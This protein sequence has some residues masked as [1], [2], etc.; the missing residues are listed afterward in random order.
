MPEEQGRRRGRGQQQQARANIEL[1]CQP[2]QAAAGEFSVEVEAIATE[3]L[4]ALSGRNLQFFVGSA[5]FS[6]PER[7]DDNGRCR[8]KITG[9]IPSS[10]EVK[11]EVQVVGQATRRDITIKIPA[12]PAA[13]GRTDK[14][15]VRY[16]L[17]DNGN[18]MVAV[19]VADDK[20]K[21]KSGV[22]VTFVADGEVNTI[23]TNA[24]GIAARECSP[25][26]VKILTPGF[27]AND[28][29]L[30]KPP[31]RWNRPEP[32][33]GWERFQ[34]NNNCRLMW[35][36][37]AVGALLLFNL[38]FLGIGPEPDSGLSEIRQKYYNFYFHDQYA[39]DKEIHWAKNAWT[40]SMDFLWS[41]SWR[42]WWI[43]FVVAIVYT[44][45][46]LW[47]EVTRSF[48]AAWRAIQERKLDQ[49]LPD[50]P[51]QTTGAE[52]TPRTEPP[53]RGEGRHG[54]YWIFVREF[55]SALVAEIAAKGIRR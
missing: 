52:T 53:R 38:A 33:S 32:E 29:D 44:P 19:L 22:P 51:P 25:G 54:E 37:L 17:R 45:I 23:A 41:L 11:I 36:W 30:E 34:T 46:A 13:T 49:D 1:R 8:K 10:R 43:L 3:G 15:N 50:V 20:G 16:T 31:R 42:L 9:P 39:V 2:P 26:K 21:E 48:K 24:N 47:D 12:D 28:F 4:R 6:S 18:Y 40:V 55:F 14:L 27:E 5:A 35:A 7:T